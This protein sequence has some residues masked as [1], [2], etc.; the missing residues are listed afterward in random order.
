M[1]PQL[2]DKRLPPQSY[3]A[4]TQI[5]SSHMADPNRNSFL[6]TSNRLRNQ[7][8]STPRREHIT[9]STPPTF[10]SVI[11]KI[12]KI[13]KDRITSLSTYFKKTEQYTSMNTTQINHIS[14]LQFW[15]KKTQQSRKQAILELW[16]ECALLMDV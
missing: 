13:I 8:A 10:T 1:P 12:I 6:I 16:I 9:Y 5:K 15:S 4:F 3:V 2:Q 14:R 7:Y 11:M